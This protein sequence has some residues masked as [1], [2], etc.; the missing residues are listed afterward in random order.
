MTVQ[1]HR[2]GEEF[3]RKLIF[4]EEVSKPPS[5]E[6][7][8]YDDSTDN[9]SDG[10]DI[11]AI[12]TEPG[13]GNYSRLTYTFG[14]TEFTSQLSGGNWE[15]E[16]SNKTMDVTNTTGYVDS[17]F[18]VVQF[19]AEGEGSSNPHLYWTGSLDQGYDLEQHDEFTL[20]NGGVSQD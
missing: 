17:Y 10:D 11:S 20:T 5:V 16:M 19:T 9:L 3:E 4:T 2:T 12:G 8:L 13:D 15:A 1:F 7:G 14:A 6:V 18:V